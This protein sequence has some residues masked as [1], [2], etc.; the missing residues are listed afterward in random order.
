ME[1]LGDK[2]A[3]LEV[4]HVFRTNS[5]VT[6]DGAPCVWLLGLPRLK[7]IVISW[8]K[9][10][11]SG[12]RFIQMAW[13]AGASTNRFLETAREPP[14]QIVHLQR[15]KSRGGWANCFYIEASQTP[16]KTFSVVVTTIAQA[17]YDSCNSD[18][19][20]IIAEV[21]FLSNNTIHVYILYSTF[22]SPPSTR[23]L[24]HVYGILAHNG[25]CCPHPTRS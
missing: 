22:I 25:T 12:Q 5:C 18:I 9:L 10:A 7:K 14:L 8:P 16:R 1:W 20:N 4:A 19:A 6:C 17:L 23:L 21:Y 3:R 2:C 15:Q 13:I 24:G 11:I